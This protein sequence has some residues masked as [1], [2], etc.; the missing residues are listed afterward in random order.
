VSEVARAIRDR[1]AVLDPERVDLIDESAL[2]AGH[3]GA[4]DGGGHFRLSIV[5]ERFRGASTVARH[6]LVYEA[7]GPLMRR[8][9]H[10]LAITA[11]TPDEAS[12]RHPTP[13]RKESA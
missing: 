5:S 6:R 3:E 10:A 13:T 7:L 2:H 12:A 4:R 8:E 11:L 9:I 1:L